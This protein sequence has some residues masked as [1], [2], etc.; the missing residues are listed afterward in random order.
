VADREEPRVARARAVGDGLRRLAVEERDLEAPAREL[1]CRRRADDSRADDDDVP[2][3]A[4]QDGT[5]EC[6]LRR[7]GRER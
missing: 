2:P 3:R 4:R 5:G 6:L 7:H 1:P